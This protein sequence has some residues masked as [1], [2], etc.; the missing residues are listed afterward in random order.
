MQQLEFFF[1]NYDW[2]VKW[3]GFDLNIGVQEIFHHG[4]TLSQT[5]GVVLESMVKV[6]LLDLPG[7]GCF[8]DLLTSLGSTVI[9][10]W[11]TMPLGVM[12][13]G[14]ERKWL[15][16]YAILLLVY[17]CLEQFMHINTWTEDPSWCS[18]CTSGVEHD[19]VLS[20]PP[21]TDWAGLE[22]SKLIRGKNTPADNNE[23]S[24]CSLLWTSWVGTSA[25]HNT[26]MY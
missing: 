8:L 13:I 14:K 5:V 22:P 4:R 1:N 19:A 6:W 15:N 17:S 9:M 26:M 21:C 23:I 20:P 11:C 3:H 24:R 2:S 7:N 10:A 16:V 25:I 18:P 12:L